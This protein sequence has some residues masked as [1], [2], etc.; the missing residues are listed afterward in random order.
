M[1]GDAVRTPSA[2]EERLARYVFE[3][4][5]EARAVRVGGKETSEQA[6]I[7]ARY[8]DLFTREQ[9]AALREA[10]EAAA[11]EERERLFRLREAC[12]SGIVAAALAEKSDALE[13]AI[14]ACRVEFDGETLPLRAAQAKLAVLESYEA[15]DA[16]GQLTFEASAAFNDDRLELLRAGEALEAELSDEP[17]PVRRSA[18]LKGVDLHRLADAVE[19]ASAR[20]ESAF[21]PLRERWLDRILGAA[22]D[23]QPHAAHVAYVRRLSPLAGVYTK[24]RSVPVCLA[25][26]AALGFD[27]E[28]C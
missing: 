17:D 21:E 22:R 4:S 19:D 24:E 6:A 11:G 23:E 3:R 5:E 28:S 2:F 13:N 14:L 25:T 10:E 1:A 26:L 15:R 7:V 27:L 8:A 20:I 12:E 16:L 9:H 18:E